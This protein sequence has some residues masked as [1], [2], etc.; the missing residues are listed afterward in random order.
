MADDRFLLVQQRVAKVREQYAAS[1]SNWINV[2]IHGD[3]GTGKTQLASTCPTPVFI[4]CFDPGG[5][6][7]AALQP[8]IAAGDIIVENK[9]E[10]DSWKSPWA[11]KE[12]E[13]EMAERQR[14]GFFDHIATYYLD[15]VT[16]WADSMMYEILRR[17]TKNITRAGQNPELQD[18]LVQQMTT[19]DW[20]GVLMG[21]PCHVVVTGHMA[22]MK[23][24][25]TGKI[26]TG[27]L[28]AGKMT[29][30]VPLVFDEKWISRVRAAGDYKLQVHADG[31]YKAET[32]MGGVKFDTF[33]QPDFKALLRKA[34]KSDS[35]K[36]SF[37]PKEEAHG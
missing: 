34:G 29:E 9:W 2:L 22:L 13:R 14:E 6:K 26:E 7:T 17:G 4:D 3:I 15:S 36:Q 27:L 12:W 23:D 31:Y 1:A 10:K 5:S 19:V 33:E 32:R 8:G 30:K 20:L 28:L 25:L 24:D 18:Y 35:G 21:L 11:F 16:K 37:F